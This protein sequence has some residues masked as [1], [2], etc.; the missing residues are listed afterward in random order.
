MILFYGIQSILS[1]PNYRKEE[2]YDHIKHFTVSIDSDIFME[3]VIKINDLESNRYL[4]DE[5]VD[6]LK[7]SK[8]FTDDKIKFSNYKINYFYDVY[9][10]LM[11]EFCNN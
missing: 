5:S 11:R 4:F 8:I 10:M 7:C 3:N 9:L 6:A 1:E 2:I